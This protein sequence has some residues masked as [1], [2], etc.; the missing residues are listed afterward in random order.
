[1]GENSEGSSSPEGMIVFVSL[2]R[3]TGTIEFFREE[4]SQETTGG[5]QVGMKGRRDL[6]L[7]SDKYL[8]DIPRGG[9]GNMSREGF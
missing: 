4:R 1:M 2:Q 6:I 7:I 9:E 8:R 3:E 5:P